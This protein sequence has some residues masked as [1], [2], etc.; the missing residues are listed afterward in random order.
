MTVSDPC[1]AIEVNPAGKIVWQAPLPGKGYE[2]IRLPE[3][4]TLVSTGG[5]ARVIELSPDGRI[6]FAAGGKQAH[7]TLGLDWLSGFDRLQNGNIVVANWL[8]HGK[9]GA[10]PHLVEFDRNN[11]VVWKWEDHQQAA[12]VT[13]V[14]V[15]NP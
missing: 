13:N 2:A 15:L 12:T 6:V 10:G 7:P 4:N 14:L 5:D 11:R 8:G 1:R 9:V 3:G